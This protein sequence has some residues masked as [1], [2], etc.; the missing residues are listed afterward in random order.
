[1]LLGGTEEK[2]R[3]FEA[4]GRDF[5]LDAKEPLRGGYGGPFRPVTYSSQIHKTERVS[6]GLSGCGESFR[7]KS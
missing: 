6:A 5:R 4:H 1:M 7:E 2:P 3:G